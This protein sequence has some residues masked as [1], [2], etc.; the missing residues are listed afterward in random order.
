MPPP[1]GRPVKAVVFDIGGILE[2]PFDDVLVPELAATLGL[3]LAR[4]AADR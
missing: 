2:P 1:G 3:P 4:L